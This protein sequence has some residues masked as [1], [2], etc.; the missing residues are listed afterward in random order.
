MNILSEKVTNEKVPLASISRFCKEYSVGKAIKKAN[1]YK[2]KGTPAIHLFT[3]LLQLVY[4]KKICK[5]YLNLGAE[6]Q[7]LSLPKHF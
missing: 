7:G 5:S 2:A 6:F 1:A 3:Y 4:T